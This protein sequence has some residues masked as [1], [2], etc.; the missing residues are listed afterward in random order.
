MSVINYVVR[1]QAGNLQRGV[2]PSETQSAVIAMPSGADLSLNLKSGDVTNFTKDGGNLV[3]TLSDGRQLVI[4]GFFVDGGTA[5]QLYFSADGL[6]H[7][8]TFG[9]TADG[10]LVES[11]AA[12]QQAGKWSPTDD[13]IFFRSA[14]LT[15][16]GD[17]EVAQAVFAPF[18]GTGAAIVGAGLVG[19]GLLDDDGGNGGG[20]DET[21]TPAAPFV[22]NPESVTTIGGDDRGPDSITITG[23]GEPGDP[24]T[25]VIGAQTQTTT[26]GADGTFSVTFDGDNFPAD[27]T[28]ESVVTVGGTANDAVLD[29]PGYIID[30]TPPEIEVT[31]GTGSVGDV[32]NTAEYDAGITLSGTGEP[33][34]TVA[35]T[36]QDITRT[37]TVAED[38][39]WSAT[40]QQGTLE[41]GDYTSDVSI[42][43]TDSFGNS[44]TTSDTVVIDTEIT[45][46]IV[47][48]VEGDDI[49][50]ADERS[51]GVDVSGTADPGA[52]VDVTIG[53]TTHTVTAD[54]NGDWTTT[55]TPD[56]VPEGTY[57]APIEAITA[58][59]NGNTATVTSDVLVDTELPFAITSTP[60]G[61]DGVINAAERGDG[62]VVAGT[63]EPGAAVTVEFA[64]NTRAAAVDDNGNW[65]VTFPASE[66][67]EGEYV[68]EAIATASDPAGNSATLSQDVPV[69][70]V[71]NALSINHPVEGDDVVNAVEASDGVILTGSAT[72]LAD[73][74]VTMNGVTRQATADASGNWQ[75]DYAAA[76]IP[77]GTYQAD[78]TA[79]SVDAAGNTNSITDSVQV[80]TEVLNFTVNESTIEGDAV[81]NGVERADGVVVTGTVE[82]GSTVEVNFGSA[83]VNAQVDAHGIWTATFDPS[84][85]PTGEYDGTFNVLATDAA[86]NTDTRVANVR[87]DTLVNQLEFDANS[88]STTVEGDGTVNAVEALDGIVLGGLV[89]EGSEV[90]L[91]FNGTDYPATVDASGTWSLTIPPE[92]IQQGSYDADVTVR[93]TDA[94]GNTDSISQIISVDT[95]APDGPVIA[96]FTRD[97]DGLRSIATEGDGNDISVAQVNIDGTVDAV[98]TSDA[99]IPALGET[100]HTFGDNVPDGS[101]LVV[102][103]RDGAGN[104]TS[105]F[106]A[107]DDENPGST[108]EI[109][110]PNLAGNNITT[111][112]LQFAEAATL[113][114]TEASIL[115]LSQTSDTVEVIG[116]A[117]DTLEVSGALKVGS[118]GGKDTYQV[119]EATLIVDSDIRIEEPSSI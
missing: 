49:V 98:S 118:A 94:A 61:A 24:V 7:E 44:F 22:D 31:A 1:D 73:V 99:Y 48:N 95:D 91:T 113:A 28:Y 97:A 9:V 8:V 83:S 13:L 112:D 65:T 64:G 15:P 25:V 56:E 68:G 75:V 114:L 81:V 79:S 60:G 29:G 12:V 38:G 5:G 115:D 63:V 46:S 36:I 14:D 43:T 33:G 93:A 109:D 89:E 10:T 18:L 110:N 54:D 11:Y 88:T 30:T 87:V 55:F 90:V 32:F 102:T 47:D 108:V 59:R 57:H 19:A 76:E 27:G 85:V 50:N 92:G 17:E 106:L 119:G 77:A 96:A 42:V 51:D 74:S 39:T 82:P 37:T 104:V 72:P 4:E 80:D 101:D 71:P 3:L 103:N 100:L 45:L 41:R 21:P 40:W 66:I 26:I 70:T 69:D 116:G 84:Q 111:I 6:L 23:G 35:L 2:V 34:A 107:L 86:G 20:G 67:P 105:T 52:E 78:I 53:D 117:D 16:V 62:L 58:D